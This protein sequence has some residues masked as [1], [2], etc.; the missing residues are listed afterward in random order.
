[1]KALHYTLA[2]VFF[3]FAGVQYNDPDPIPWMLTYAAVGTLCL[4]AGLGGHFPWLSLG[5]AILLSLWMAFYVPGVIAWF[6]QG[7]PSIVGAM[8]AGTPYIEDMREFLG[9]LLCVA[10]LLHLWRL[11]RRAEAE[12][13]A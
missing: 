12:P 8:K 11:G 1:M 3:L 6:A 4:L 7:M 13:E 9:L 5:L 2:A 10:A